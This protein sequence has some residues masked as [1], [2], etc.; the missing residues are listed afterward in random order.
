MK[1]YQERVVKRTS[2]NKAILFRIIASDK[3]DIICKERIVQELPRVLHRD[4][5]DFIHLLYDVGEAEILT[6]K[7][8]LFRAFHK[9]GGDFRTHPVSKC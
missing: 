7:Y 1:R 6:E 4:V 2:D 9:L 3:K 5:D 8:K